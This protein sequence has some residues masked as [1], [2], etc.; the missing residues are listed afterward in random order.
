MLEMKEK[1]EKGG[2]KEREAP[3]KEG[4]RGTEKY[5]HILCNYTIILLPRTH[6]QGV[7]QSPSV[8]LS[9]YVCQHKNRQIWISRQHSEIKYHYSVR[10]VGKLNFFCLLGA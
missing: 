8:C 4:V 3:E 7:K 10:N 1:R 5:L 9:A 2:G 6:A